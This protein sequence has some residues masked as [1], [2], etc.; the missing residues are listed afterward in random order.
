MGERCTGG[1]TMGNRFMRRFFLLMGVAG[2]LVA[3]TDRAAVQRLYS[4]IVRRLAPELER[5]QQNTCLET[6]RRF[7]VDQSG[8]VFH[9]DES[10]VEV[11][12]VKGREFYGAQGAALEKDDASGL[13]KPGLVGT[14]ELFLYTQQIFFDPHNEM[15][16]AGV[17]EVDGHYYH[18]FLYKVPLAA[19]G[20]LLATEYGEANVAY[21]GEA[22]I[23]VAM[24]TPA[25]LT[26]VGDDIPAHLRTK[27]FRMTMT[28]DPVGP[29]V[30]AR[31]PLLPRSN[32]IVFERVDGQRQ[33]STN[34]WSHCR[35]FSSESRMVDEDETVTEGNQAAPVLVPLE[36]GSL[37][38]GLQQTLPLEGLT[39]GTRLELTVAKDAKFGAYRLSKGSAVPARVMRVERRKAETLVSLAIESIPAK[40][41]GGAPVLLR[42]TALPE[43]VE[44]KQR[45]V[46]LVPGTPKLGA[47]RAEATAEEKEMRLIEGMSRIDLPGVVTM[48][49]AAEASTI[50]PVTIYWKHEEALPVVFK[51]LQPLPR[52]RRP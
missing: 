9:A 39:P 52:F 15:R 5:V 17:K 32:L 51:N 37:V 8:R 35:E 36:R 2:S 28:F 43:K 40:S 30:S 33:V 21:H 4:D 18:Q 6:L 14:G 12:S 50:E 22:L 44:S 31:P 20:F 24:E 34:V 10:R 47:A 48:A 41:E 26:I 42:F 29:K 46:R 27:S 3:Q 38:T 19:R 23:D 49:M 45:E 25:R 13:V 7:D 1:W 16:Y 11:G